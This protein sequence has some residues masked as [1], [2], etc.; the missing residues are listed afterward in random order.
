L[1]GHADKVRQAQWSQDESRI[2]TVSDD[3]KVRQ[4]YTQPA[5]V[6]AAACSRG[7]VRNMT[8]NEWAQYMI[9]QPYRATCTELP[10]EK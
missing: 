9:D 8:R 6:I 1:V 5:N 4:F 3:G 7:A 10:A 2:F